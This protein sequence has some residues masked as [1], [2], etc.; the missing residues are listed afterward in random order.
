MAEPNEARLD[1]VKVIDINSRAADEF[2]EP[3]PS[4]SEPDKYGITAFDPLR[5]YLKEIG[6]YRLLTRE[7]EQATAVRC[8]QFNDKEARNLLVVSNLR[9]VVK[10]AF[11]YYNPN[12]ILLDLIQEGNLGLMHA[13]DKFNPDRGIRFSTYASFWIRA[14]ILKYIMDRWSAVKVG[15]TQG[16][17]KLFYRL[18]KE[19]RQLEGL[20][21]D[22]TADVIA[23]RLNVKA[24]E[25]VEMEKR[26]AHGDLSL[27]NLRY[28]EGEETLLDTLASDDDTEAIVLAKNERDRGVDLINQFRGRLPTRE[29]FIFNGRICCEEPLT[30][31]AIAV[32]L[33]ISRERVR[34]IESRMMGKFKAF[35]KQRGEKMAKARAKLDGVTPE[36]IESVTR[37]DSQMRDVA[38][39]YH[40]LKEGKGKLTA[41]ETA[42]ELNKPKDSV[43]AAISV[44]NK[45]IQELRSV[46][47][48]ELARGGGE[49][50]LQQVQEA[51][52]SEVATNAP[53]RLTVERAGKKF[54]IILPG[55]P[56]YD[57]LIRFLGL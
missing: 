36:E 35:I 15:T 57:L 33:D 48:S 42:K 23:Q 51:A 29:L 47:A 3:L 54:E 14:H 26:L 19:K 16:Q 8:R 25:V 50:R 37:P 53:I 2:V 38:M 49:P 30:L 44:V 40:G 5:A 55:G 45:K 10:I 11:E 21:I 7:E 24:E 22:P 41:E 4:G 31:E 1:V 34:Q 9:L 20:G 12:V 43:Y 52:R 28:N 13:P 18:K 27:D 56:I 6:Q 32:R 17:R 39:L 46:R